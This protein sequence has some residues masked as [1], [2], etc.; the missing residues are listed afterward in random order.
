MTS[1]NFNNNHSE[2]FKQIGFKNFKAN[3]VVYRIDDKI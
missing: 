3:E 2:L 1:I